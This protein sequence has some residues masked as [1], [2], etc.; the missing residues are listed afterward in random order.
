MRFLTSFGMTIIVI[1]RG[2]EKVRPPMA[3]A[4][5]LPNISQKPC[6]S[7]RSEESKMDKCYFA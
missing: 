3:V 1:N 2:G 4:P 7:E 5:S 6:H